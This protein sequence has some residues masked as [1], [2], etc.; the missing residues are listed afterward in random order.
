MKNKLFAVIG[1]GCLPLVILALNTVP[2]VAQEQLSRAESLKYAFAVAADLGEMLHTPVPT[3]PDIKRPVAV[4]EN[5]YGAL[6]LPE[7]KLTAAALQKP[8]QA[9]IPVGQ[10]WLLNLVPM[11]D[12][13]PV[14]GDRLRFVHVTSPEGSAKTPCCVLM[15]RSTDNGGLELLVLGKDQTP[16]LTAPLKPITQTQDNPITMTAERESDGG[17][18]TLRLLGKY[19]VSFMVTDPDQF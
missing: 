17:L 3:D 1:R 9:G 6:V 14:A 2:A 4:R 18:I 12:H 8:D 11:R 13:Q 5:D 19:E 15:V 7:A 10:L 16:L